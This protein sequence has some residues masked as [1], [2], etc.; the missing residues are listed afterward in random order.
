M[1]PSKGHENLEILAGWLEGQGRVKFHD[2]SKLNDIP[3]K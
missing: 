3:P 1:W 2:W